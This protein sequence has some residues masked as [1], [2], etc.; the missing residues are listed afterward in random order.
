M[1]RISNSG[2]ARAAERSADGLPV[3]MVTVRAPSSGVIETGFMKVD[4]ADEPSEPSLSNMCWRDSAT[5]VAVTSVPVENLS[6]SRS[7][8]VH[9][10]CSSSGVQDSARYGWGTIFSSNLN[11]DSPMP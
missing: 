5:F 7:A 2:L 3:T 9:V 4:G 6:P 8:I 1:S 11:N 10:R